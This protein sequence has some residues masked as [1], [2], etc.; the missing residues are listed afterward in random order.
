MER[1]YVTV[2]L[3][4]STKLSNK[5]LEKKKHKQRNTRNIY[6]QV[7]QFLRFYNFNLDACRML[8]AN[9]LWS[10]IAYAE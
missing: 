2:T 9:L 10:S 3:C 1:H 4:I 7:Y 8:L 5:K 6:D